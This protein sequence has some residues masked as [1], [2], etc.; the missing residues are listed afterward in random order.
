[1][2]GRP[3]MFAITAEVASRFRTSR[4]LL[5]SATCES[6]MTAFLCRKGWRK[7]G[8]Q[9]HMTGERRERQHTRVG[10]EE[11]TS[12][13]GRDHVESSHSVRTPPH[14]RNILRVVGIPT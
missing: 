4:K 7:G 1:M 6:Y 10:S 11:S 14:V 3:P 8:Q 9:T 13:V 5:R 12:Y 2:R